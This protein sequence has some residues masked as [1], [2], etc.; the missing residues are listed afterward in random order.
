[1]LASL[2]S[3]RARIVTLKAQISE[4]TRLLSTIRAEQALVR[5]RLDSYRYP[6][7]TLPNEL[8]SDVFIHFLPTY[9]LC[10]PLTGT[11][12]PQLLLQI[13]RKWRQIALSTP[14]LWRAI[15][16]QISRN[17]AV[18]Q[19]ERV[20]EEWLGR[21]GDWP[22][23]IQI[24]QDPFPGARD[25]LLGVIDA[26]RTRWEHIKSNISGEDSLTVEG[27]LPLLCHLDIYISG[28]A[29]PAMHFPD[30]PRLRTAVLSH[31]DYP[32]LLPWSQLTSLTLIGKLPHECT[33]VL[34]HASS[35][36]YCELVLFDVPGHTSVKSDITLPNLES[37]VL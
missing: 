20:K 12:S 25:K 37:L 21:S 28:G 10:P 4:I 14:T 31:F 1:M 6:V 23:S 16:L 7:L 24:D 17:V 2:E 26:H 22:L 3:D 8:V 34:L 9:P 35:L 5:E 15:T 29:S 19:H 13:C 11:H 18:E 32:A 30:M 36:R 33:P 27:V